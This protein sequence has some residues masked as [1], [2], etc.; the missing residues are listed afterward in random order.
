MY[1]GLNNLGLNS[2]SQAF[3]LSNLF[4]ND[5]AGLWY[6]TGLT[7]GYQDSAGTTALTAP[8]VGTAD[9]PQGYVTDKSGNTLH[10]IQATAAAR[11]TYSAR[12]NLLLATATLS[13]QNVTTVSAPYTLQFTGSGTVTLSG[14]STAG[15]LVG[16]GTLTF[17][18]TA[19][20][21]TLTV[22]GSV[23]L[24]QLELGSS[25]TTYQSITD[26]SNYATSGFPLFRKFDG[27]DDGHATAAFAAGTLT[28]NMDFF[29]VVRRESAAKFVL[30]ANGAGAVSRYV[31]YV[32]AAGGATSATG[33]DS[34]GTTYLVDGVAVAATAVA[35]DAA[36]TVGAWHVVEVRSAGMSLWTGASIGLYTGYLFNGSLGDVVLCPAQTDA[37]RAKIRRALAAQYGVTVV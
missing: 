19:G 16:G 24:A 20:T 25:A 12:K 37:V 17:T 18:P 4:L 8:G 36:I 31:G 33:A 11:P 21:L 13:T 35:L 32:D 29:C 7:E 26:A 6:G 34:V 28:S 9:C 2:N 1:T 22:S 27:I 5:A 14:T 10:G 30:F 15:P 3:S 23:T